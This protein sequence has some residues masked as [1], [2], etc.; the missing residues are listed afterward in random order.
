M[1]SKL[2]IVV[3]WLSLLSTISLVNGE[4]AGGITHEKPVDLDDNTFEIAIND[5]VNPFWFL[6]FYAP[7]CGHCKRMAPVLDTVAPKLKGKMAIG[8]IDCTQQKTVCNEHKIR[9]FPTL[10][11]S[12]DGK[13]FDYSGG[14]DEKALVA[15]AEKMSSP[16]VIEIRRLEEAK[17]FAYNSADEGIVF[18]GSGK[19]DSDLLKVFTKVARK[20]QASGY[21]MWLE[22]LES[23]TD[24]G[25]DYSYVDR[26]EVGIVEPRR[27]ETTGSDVTEEKFEAWVKDQNIPTLAIL[28][29][30]NFP[31]ISKNGRPLVMGIVDIDNKELVEQLRLHMIELILNAPQAF[32]EKY[33]YGIFDGKKWQKYLQ[34]FGVRQEDNPQFMILAPTDKPGEK[35]YWR[36]ETYTKLP[37]FLKAVENGSIPPRSPEKPQ[38]NDDPMQWMTQKFVQY[39][40][41]SVFPIIMLVGVII[42]AMTPD[43]DYYKEPDEIDEDEL[44][45]DESK[46]DK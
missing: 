27:W 29:P 4:Y 7:W 1:V 45:E 12:V 32:V 37:D 31:K 10:K 23:P 5:E 2:A 30:S 18:L 21:F 3:Q 26:V 38:F 35:T 42:W 19:G 15:F 34:Q 16:P 44:I 6:K 43:T 24:D 46:K 22:Q 41:F 8:K 20:Y 40:P 9:G 13:I 28:T 33:Y 14:R 25:N 36:N 11:Y 39:L 17:K